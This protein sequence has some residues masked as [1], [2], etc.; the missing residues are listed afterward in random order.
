MLNLVSLISGLLFGLGL[1]ISGMISPGKVIG[2]LDLAGNWDPS[3][4]FVMGGGVLVTIIAFR[5][6]LKRETP[7]FGGRFSLPTKTDVD[8]RLALGA[9]LFGIGWGLGGLCPGPAI[10][11]L[12]YGNAKILVFVTAMIGGILIAKLLSGAFKKPA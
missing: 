6:I 2:F 8:K 1:A 9:V 5:F 10:S 11:S 3:L 4:A 7:L 12:A